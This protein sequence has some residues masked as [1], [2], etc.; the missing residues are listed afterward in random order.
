VGE[1][2][3]VVVVLDVAFSLKCTVSKVSRSYLT[4]SGSLSEK[5]E[6]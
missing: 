2:H 5:G 4:Y 1:K 3:R 6:L